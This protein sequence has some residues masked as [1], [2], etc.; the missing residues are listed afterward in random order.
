MVGQE[1]IST[2]S[3]W[4]CAGVG[5]PEACSRLACVVRQAWLERSGSFWKNSFVYSRAEG[6]EKEG[7]V[8]SER[9]VCVSLVGSWIPGERICRWSPEI[10]V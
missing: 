10:W 4:P 9:M 8:R 2:G 5:A 1:N 7:G 3:E 6:K